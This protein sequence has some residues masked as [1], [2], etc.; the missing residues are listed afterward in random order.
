MGILDKL[1][2]KEGVFTKQQ[3]ITAILYLA[4]TAD[5][6]VSPEEEE[7]F[8]AASNEMRLLRKQTPTE[9]NEMVGEIRE[10]ILSKGREVILEAA[11]AALP[12]D[13]QETAFALAVDFSMLDDNLVFVEKKFIEELR[14]ALGISEERATLI[15]EVLD[16]KNR[17]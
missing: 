4:V 11:V 6:E 13:L 14:R 17:A 10:G 12:A 15:V 8:I 7:A 3:A 5:R 16:I 1:L 9:F 2:N